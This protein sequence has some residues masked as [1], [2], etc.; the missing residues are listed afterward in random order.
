MGCASCALIPTSP[1]ATGPRSGYWRSSGRRPTSVPTAP[2]CSRSPR[3]GR[4]SYHTH[5]ARANVLRALDIPADA[6][7]LE[8]GAGCG[9]ISR[10]LGET[11]PR[12]TP[13]NR[14]CLAPGSGASAPG[15]CPTSRCSAA[16]SRTCRSDPVYDLVVVVGVLEYVGGG[17]PDPEPYLSFLRECRSAA[18]P[19]RVAR[20]GD[21]EQARGQVPDRHR[22]GSQRPAVRLR[23]GLSPRQPGADVQRHGP[24]RPGQQLAV[25]PLSC[26]ACSRLQA[27]PGGLRHRRAARRSSGPAGEPARRSPA[28][29][30]APEACAWPARSGSGRSSSATASARTSATRSWSSAAPDGPSSLWPD[31]RLARYFSINRR[32]EYVAVDE[33][34]PGRRRVRFDRTYSPE[35]GPLISDGVDV[36]GL[37]AGTVVPARSST[38]PT[39]AGRRKL[40]QRWLRLVRA[41]TDW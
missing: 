32:R 7:V 19:R 2:R 29:S 16:I 28:A 24:A 33:R 15:T 35:P 37:R 1:T 20:A 5:P 41:T 31:D 12:S 30:P 6:V 4:S 22:R 3:V 40:L 25:S 18:A 36:L 9:P 10:Y 26:S 34:P 38:P 8:V 21:R 27:H 13:S 23:R 14:S 39:T 11:A 17:E